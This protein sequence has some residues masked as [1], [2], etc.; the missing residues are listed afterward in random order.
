MVLDEAYIEYAEDDELPDGLTY[1]ARYPNLLIS[2]TFSK[3]LWLG[4]AAGGLWHLLGA[5]CRCAQ[6]RA[7]AIQRQQPGLADCGV[8]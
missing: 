6:S 2:R 4:G 5:D 8:G 7:P 3:G 1:L